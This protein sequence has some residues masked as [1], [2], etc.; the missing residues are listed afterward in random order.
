MT[1]RNFMSL[2][3]LIYKL[4]KLNLYEKNNKLDDSFKKYFIK[5]C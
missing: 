3:N 4:K 1:F 2:N 5:F